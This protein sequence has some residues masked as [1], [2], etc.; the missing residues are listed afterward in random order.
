MDMTVQVS[1][2]V[3]PQ[4]GLDLRGPESIPA[5]FTT[6]QIVEG[7]LRRERRSR[8]RGPRRSADHGT[9]PAASPCP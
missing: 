6:S 4:V 1:A 7:A 2:Q 8:H 3:S 5:A 9:R